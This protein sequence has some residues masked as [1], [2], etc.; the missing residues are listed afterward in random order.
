MAK[1]WVGGIDAQD[2]PA[3]GHAERDESGGVSKILAVAV[4]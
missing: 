3:A 1:V 4:C 2:P